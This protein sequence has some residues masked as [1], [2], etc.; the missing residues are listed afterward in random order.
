MTT[1]TER[2]VDGIAEFAIA[3]FARDNVEVDFGIGV[4]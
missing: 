2:V 4:S 1:E 3:R